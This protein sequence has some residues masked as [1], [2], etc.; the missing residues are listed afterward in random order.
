[1]TFRRFRGRTSWFTMCTD[2]K[3]FVC[4][5][6]FWS[7]SSIFRARPKSS[8]AF[9]H[10][11]VARQLVL[12]VEQRERGHPVVARVAIYASRASPLQPVGQGLAPW[13][14]C[15]QATL[16]CLPS[17]HLWRTSKESLEKETTK[18]FRGWYSYEVRS[19]SFSAENYQHYSQDTVMLV[20]CMQE[21]S[22]T[23]VREGDLFDWK[24]RTQDTLPP[25]QMKHN[26]DTWFLKW[27][28]KGTRTVLFVSL[29]GHVLC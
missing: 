24:S 11:V 4:R 6:Q 8:I 23:F 13:F 10:V 28:K 14:G 26:L 29:E 9:F 20:N 18:C 22:Q 2:K 16:Y 1:M 21:L 27:K 5:W 3:N 17:L 15:Y 7:M 19:F 25:N 12:F